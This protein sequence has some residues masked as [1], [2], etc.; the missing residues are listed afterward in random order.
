MLFSKLKNLNLLIEK[1]NSQNV[2]LDSE[3]PL[4]EIKKKVE[5]KQKIQNKSLNL[6]ELSSEIEKLKM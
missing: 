6:G 2:K 4:N 3:L 1:T 5:S